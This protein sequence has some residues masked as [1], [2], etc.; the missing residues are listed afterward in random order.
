MDLHQIPPKSPPKQHTEW[1][2]YNHIRTGP[3]NNTSGKFKGGTWQE[4]D[5]AGWGK[6]QFMLLAPAQK[7]IHCGQ[8]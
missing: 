5:P 7:V 6:Y 4:P 3:N 8:G 1:Q 2:A